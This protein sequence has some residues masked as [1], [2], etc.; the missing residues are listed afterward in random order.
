MDKSSKADAWTLS[1]IKKILTC[2]SLLVE[3][4]LKEDDSTETLKSPG[5]GE[6]ELTESTPV[7]LIILDIDAGQPLSYSSS[8]LVSSK[9]SLSRSSN[10]RSI[11]DELICN[12]GISPIC[13]FLIILYLQSNYNKIVPNPRWKIDF[14]IDIHDYNLNIWP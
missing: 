8:R 10:V 1:K 9:D 5:S 11:G 4:F 12:I 6:E 13:Q 14:D 2:S 3:G 7:C